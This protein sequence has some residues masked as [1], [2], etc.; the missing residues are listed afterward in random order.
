MIKNSAGLLTRLHT[1]A[2]SP[3]RVDRYLRS[4]EFLSASAIIQLCPHNAS[5]DL[6]KDMLMLF[7]LH[8]CYWFI[9]GSPLSKQ[10]FSQP[11]HE[12]GAYTF[13]KSLDLNKKLLK[14]WKW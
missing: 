4:E 8:R 10:H 12:P 14:Y 5:D 11:I 7:S 9:S 2:V 6:E 1:T 3:L 13:Q